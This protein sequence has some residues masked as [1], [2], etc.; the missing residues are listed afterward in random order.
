MSTG[1]PN[2]GCGEKGNFVQCKLLR[3]AVET[4]LLW[5]SSIVLPQ[6]CC[7]NN[8]AVKSVPWP[9]T[10]SD[11]Q[12]HSVMVTW[13]CLDPHKPQTSL[14]FQVQELKGNLL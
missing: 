12:L 6:G 9:G 10:F 14:V 7:E 1:T 5:N 8:V 4:A 3:M 11:S 13:L 2:S